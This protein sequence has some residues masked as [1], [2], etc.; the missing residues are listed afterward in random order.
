MADLNMGMN[1]LTVRGKGAGR[2]KKG[3][4]EMVKRCGR[5]LISASRRVVSLPGALDS[6]GQLRPAIVHELE[7]R[8]PH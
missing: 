7:Q 3:A 6:A 5:R 8:I 4:I 2:D 1:A